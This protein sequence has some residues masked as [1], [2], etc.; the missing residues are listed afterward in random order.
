MSKTFA[1]WLFW[2]GMMQSFLASVFVQVSLQNLQRLCMELDPPF[3]A[4]VSRAQINQFETS[5]LNEIVTREINFY[6]KE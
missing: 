4:N 1:S 6:T 2:L 5:L 3:D